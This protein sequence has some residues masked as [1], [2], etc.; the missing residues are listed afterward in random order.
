[1]ILTSIDSLKLMAIL[2]RFRAAVSKAP[3][4]AQV[5]D[6]ITA[7][8]PDGSLMRLSTDPL[9]HAQGVELCRSFGLGLIDCDPQAWF[10]WDGRNVAIRMEPSVLIHEVGHYQC[11]AAHRRRLPD[12]GLGAGPE[13]GIGTAAANAAQVIHGAAADMEEG[14]SSLLG[15]LWE[16]ELGQPAILA[17]LEQN[18]LEGGD[19]PRNVGHFIRMVDTLYRHR[20][21]Q[22]DGRPTRALR[23]TE[24]APFFEDWFAV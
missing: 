20:L 17:F 16:A 8:I 14:L 12:F 2:P 3:L 19:D 23:V 24:D 11:A 10:T 22:S 5:L 4:A 6:V 21:I 18:W 9:H 13:T 7:H 15:I 1:M